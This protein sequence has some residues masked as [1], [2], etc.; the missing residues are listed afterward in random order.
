[1]GMEEVKKEILDN[2]RNQAKQQIKEAEKERESIIKSAESR[3]EAIKERIEKQTDSAIE[4]YKA[5]TLAEASSIVKKQRLSLEKELINEVFD[6][7]RKELAG[8]SSKKREDHLN[9]LLKNAGKHFSFS[10]LYCSKKD[11]ALLKKHK[12]SETDITGGL[13]LED[14][15][16]ELRVDLSYETLLSS[17]KQND[18]SSI[19]KALFG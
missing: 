11:I 5:M 13:I 17:I 10:K 15:S 2:A 14:N 3:V 8:I 6:A 18:V 4:Q 9:R 16:G 19:S 1:M 12:P 7:A